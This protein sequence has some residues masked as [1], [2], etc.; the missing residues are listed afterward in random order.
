MEASSCH[1]GA[2][3]KLGLRVHGLIVGSPEK[4]RADP[5]VLRSLCSHVLPSGKMEVGTAPAANCRFHPQSFAYPA[6]VKTLPGYA[7]KGR[8][9]EK[10]WL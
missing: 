5:A 9:D 7:R 4:K 10:F 6:H 8:E 1:A 2:K 3:E